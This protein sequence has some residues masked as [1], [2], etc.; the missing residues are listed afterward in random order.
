MLENAQA[1]LIEDKDSGFVLLAV[2]LVSLIL[3]AVASALTTTVRGRLELARAVAGSAEAEALADAGVHLAMLDIDD[4][5]RDGH[6]ARRFP[7]GGAPVSCTAPDGKSTITIEVRDEAG[8]ININSRNE[9]LLLAFVSGFG[10]DSETSQLLMSRLLDY[11]DGDQVTREGQAEA[12]VELA[13]DAPSGGRFKNRPFDVIEEIAQVPGFPHSASAAALPYLTVYSDIDG[14]DPALS[15]PGLAAIVAAGAARTG[16]GSTASSDGLPLT[17]LARSTQ[18][19]LAIVATASLQSGT[20][21]TREAIVKL[22]VSGEAYV[23]RRWKQ[24]PYAL[25]PSGDD[26]LPPC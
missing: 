3:V 20:R 21:Y 25:S 4:T 13:S 26:A 2:L 11:R 8:K 1:S 23:V 15:P 7:I 6:R 22:S 10:Q 18:R 12:S 24:A 5:R 19:A 14:F 9:H 16:F 17:F